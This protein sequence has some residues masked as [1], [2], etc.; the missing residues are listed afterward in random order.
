MFDDAIQEAHWKRFQEYAVR[1]RTLDLADI[2]IIRTTVWIVLMQWCP[3]GPLLPRLQRLSGVAINSNSLCYTMLFSPSI[4]HLS[5]KIAEDADVGALGMVMQAVQPA[6]TSALHLS[7]D[8]EGPESG[9]RSPLAQVQFWNLTQLHTLTVLHAAVLTPVQIRA[10]AEFPD[11]RI[12]NLHLK[13][14]KQSQ[15]GLLE[16][17]AGFHKLRELSLTGKLSLI[18]DFLAYTTPP[19]L[20]A[21][22]IEARDLCEGS[23]VSISQR[24]APRSLDAVYTTLTPSLRRF[25][26]TLHCECRS[27]D[28]FPDSDTLLIPLCDSAV[29]GLHSICFQFEKIKFHLKDSTL[30]TLARTWPDLVEFEVAP[31]TPPPQPVS[32]RD[33]MP[34]FGLGPPILVPHTPLLRPVY[35]HPTIK[36][37]A[38]FAHTHPHLERLSILSLDLDALPD[39]ET[40]PL[41]EHGLRHFSV[42]KL[43]R[44]H[45]LLDHAIALDMLFPRL[46]VATACDP[47]GENQPGNSYAYER[48]SKDELQ[49]LLLALQVGRVGQYRARASRTCG[50][51][52]EITMQLRGWHTAPVASAE[53]QDPGNHFGPYAP[54]PSPTHGMYYSPMAGGSPFSNSSYGPPVPMGHANHSSPDSG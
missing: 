32:T 43:S 11:L 39:L 14:H 41:L 2:D 20:E 3:R 35:D 38:A 47:Q 48:P 46:D 5:I 9:K 52:A 51:P 18:C 33:H 8:D 49:L 12:L 25:R 37:L 7:I 15:M 42:H 44:T 29:L 27:D 54:S 53:P 34:F 13:P 21:L 24:P 31:K 26:A 17:K 22:Y 1:I 30:S 28:H 16:S 45:N 10:L 40:I 4:S 6:L 50:E 19:D 36:T 23:P